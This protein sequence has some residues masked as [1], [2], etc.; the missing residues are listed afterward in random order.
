[1]E[2][3]ILLENKQEAK[4]RENS[5]RISARISTFSSFLFLTLHVHFSYAASNWAP[6]QVNARGIENVL[7]VAR[8]HKVKVFAPSTIAVFGP[9]TPKENT[10][11]ST[12]MRPT[13]IYGTTKVY[14]GACYGVHLC[15]FI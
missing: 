3:E 2:S 6:T 11:N 9:D 5:R 13:T 1:M 14:L 12:I 10:P 8:L 7:E 4:Y 15:S